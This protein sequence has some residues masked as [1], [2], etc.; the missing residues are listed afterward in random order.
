MSIQQFESRENGEFEETA[1]AGESGDSVPKAAEGGDLAGENPADWSESAE[2]G[3]AAMEFARAA[4][5]EGEEWPDEA[6]EDGKIAEFEAKTAELEAKSEDLAAQLAEARDQLL[7]KAADFENFRK[8]MN[9]EK[10]GA[11]E[12][13]NQSLLLDIIPVID[14]F[15]RAIQ[16]AQASAELAE[17]PAGKAMLDGI[18]MIEKRLTGQ[19]EAKWGLKRFISVGEPFDPNIHEAMFMEKSPDI[20]EPVVQE[21]FA[22]GYMLKDRVI[23]AA[24]VKVLMPGEKGD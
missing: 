11:I 18:A 24:K 17:L 9:Q 20:E 23:R 22:K 7:R 21:E 14:D 19:L 2:E 8:R 4:M 13:A 6:D 1:Q 12:F 15:D 5:A 16:S 3:D 10:Q